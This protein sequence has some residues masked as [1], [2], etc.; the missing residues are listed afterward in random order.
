MSTTVREAIRP[1]VEAKTA[2]FVDASFAVADRECILRTEK[3]NSTIIA[4]EDKITSL[5]EEV[6]ELKALMAAEPDDKYSLTK[7]K[8]IRLMK[9]LGYYE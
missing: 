7:A 2:T 6:R 9:D 5:K 4:L 1:D 8:L 3:A